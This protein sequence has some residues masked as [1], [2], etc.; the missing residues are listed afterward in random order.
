MGYVVG[1]FEYLSKENADIAM[2]EL[3]TIDK[4][5]MQLNYDDP[6][7]VYAVYHKMIRGRVFHT[8]QGLRYLLHLKEYLENVN[9]PLPGFIVPIPEDIVLPN[10]PTDK[11]GVGKDAGLEQNAMEERE[12]SSSASVR[13]WKNRVRKLEEKI[14]IGKIVIGFLIL[15]VIGMFIIASLGNSPTILNYKKE[16]QNEYAD[17]QTQLE[18]KE[19]ELREREHNLEEQGF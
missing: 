14:L 3:E 9:V 17:W 18:E 4:V 1:D 10:F 7:M 19:A 5:E 15:L 11:D 2:K 8:P 13:R 12:S 6:G 16:I